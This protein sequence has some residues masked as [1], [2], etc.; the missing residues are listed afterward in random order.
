[1][2]IPSTAREDTIWRRYE[3]APGVELNI[4]LAYLR[5]YKD[6]IAKLIQLARDLLKP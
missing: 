2:D 5:K 3:V 1:M 4:Q 6:G